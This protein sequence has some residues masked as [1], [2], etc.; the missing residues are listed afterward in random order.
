ME[1]E[2][3]MMIGGTGTGKSTKA[4]EI[5]KKTGFYVF[6]AD[7]IENSHSQLDEQINIDDL[8]I[9]RLDNQLSLGE[10]FILDGK[11]LS[12]SER[13][14]IINKAKKYGFTII[15]HNFGVGT[16]ESK[17]RRLNNPRDMPPIHWEQV[18]DFDLR[19]YQTPNICEGFLEIIDY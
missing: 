2:L 19:N 14:N 15:G 1:K 4:N 9:N 12:V 3:H 13:T 16:D 8:I 11:C 18:F 10:S 7:E 6:S 17:Q 5:S